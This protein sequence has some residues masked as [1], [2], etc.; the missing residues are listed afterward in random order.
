MVLN[1]SITRNLAE[2]KLFRSCVTICG[3]GP[4]FAALRPHTPHLRVGFWIMVGR[5]QHLGCYW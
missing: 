1:G 4:N 3:V 5:G 2:E